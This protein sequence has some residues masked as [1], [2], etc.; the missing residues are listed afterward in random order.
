MCNKVANKSGGAKIKDGVS[1]I[2]GKTKREFDGGTPVCTF[3][4]YKNHT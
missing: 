2:Q 3:D 4:A 1:Q